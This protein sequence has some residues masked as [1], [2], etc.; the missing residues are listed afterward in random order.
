MYTYFSRFL[1]HTLSHSGLTGVSRSNQVA[2][3]FHLDYRVKPDNDRKRKNSSFK[4]DGDS[5]GKDA[6]LK[7]DND[8]IVNVGR[9]MVEMLGVL[10]IIG[11]LSVGAISGYSKAMFKYKLNKHAE[12]MN[13]VINAVARNVHSFN[14][15]GGSTT[16]VPY[17]V[18]MG[19]IPTEM[20]K[21][22][23]NNFVYDI[24][25]QAWLIFISSGGSN[26][27]LSTYST[28]GASSLTTKSVDNLKICKNILLA[29][30]ENHDS[31]F[32]VYSASNHNTSDEKQKYL[33]GDMY[34]QADRTCLKD[35]SLNDI[36]DFCTK[37]YGINSA[38]G[39][40]LAISWLK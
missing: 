13:T 25:G 14:N 34:C 27:L 39:T 11:V 15:I 3:L 22:N 29:A 18:K 16:I 4:P 12:Q 38:S 30:K 8:N 5:M 35:L 24:F 17:L 19:E 33:H 26:I 10:A 40:E 28:T 1:H 36:Y 32:A 23:V 9:S 2:N 37:H 20:V 6:S 31:I 21:T 7:P